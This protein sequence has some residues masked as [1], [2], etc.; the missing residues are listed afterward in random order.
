MYF[1]ISSLLFHGLG[2][3]IFSEIVK[4]TVPRNSGDISEISYLSVGYY[5]F[6]FTNDF[7]SDFSV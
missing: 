4:K 7:L 6:Y 5:K 1:L 2:I 3:V